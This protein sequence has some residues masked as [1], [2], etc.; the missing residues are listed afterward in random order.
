MGFGGRL[1]VWGELSMRVVTLKQGEVVLTTI[2]GVSGQDS[3]H[4]QVVSGSSNQ[5]DIDSSTKVVALLF[6]QGRAS[7]VEFDQFWSMYL[8]SWFPCIVTFRVPLPFDEVLKLSS[9][10]II[11][12]ISDALHFILLFSIDKVKWWSGKVWSVRCHFVIW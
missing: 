3:S 4:H 12:V 9:S 5:E 7:M 6:F 11:L 10:S 8:I 2:V 1:G